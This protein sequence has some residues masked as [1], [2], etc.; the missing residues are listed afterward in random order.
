V[1][2]DRRTVLV[3]AHAGGLRRRL[4]ATAWAVLEE[5]LARSTGVPPS[6][7]ALAAT[8]TLAG[9]LGMSKDTIAHALARLRSAGIVEP[10]QGRAPAG[11]FTTGGYL[12]AVPDCVT[13]LDAVPE[14]SSASV[15]HE[16]SRYRATRHTG[17]Q[18]A[19]SLDD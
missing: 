18:L 11:T 16:T 12:I 5:L 10:A 3:H 7:V 6:C 1:T 19:L 2:T 9:D 4:G 14:V 8:R 17:S 13:V 15:R